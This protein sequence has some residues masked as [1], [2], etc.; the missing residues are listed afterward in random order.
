MQRVSEKVKMK[1]ARQ[2][3]RKIG[4]SNI[5]E[6]PR[7]GKSEGG[8]GRGEERAGEKERKGNWEGKEGL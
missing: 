1:K 2:R 5:A 8:R 7:E 3:T 6:T 4:E